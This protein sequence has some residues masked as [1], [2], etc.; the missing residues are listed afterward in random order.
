M[1]MIIGG[2]HSIDEP[3]MKAQF[4]VDWPNSWFLSLNKCYQIQVSELLLPLYDNLTNLK[5]LKSYCEYIVSD[6]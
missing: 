1:K 2:P 3:V 6:K 4:T 5:L